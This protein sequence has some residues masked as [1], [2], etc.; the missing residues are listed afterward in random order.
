MDAF[1]LQIPGELSKS[2]YNVVSILKKQPQYDIVNIII[3]NIM[4]LQTGMVNFYQTGFF[5]H[6][7]F[8]I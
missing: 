7:S 1:L 5:I 8:C 3:K 6:D 4:L 2:G